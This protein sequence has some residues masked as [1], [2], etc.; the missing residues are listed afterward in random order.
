MNVRFS[1]PEGNLKSVH[2]SLL[3]ISYEEDEPKNISKMNFLTG[4]GF[5]AV[6]RS[7]SGRRSAMICSLSSTADLLS[8]SGCETHRTA[9]VLLYS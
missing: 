2:T 1:R 3:E 9:A 5:P 7:T 4:T 8:S 6:T